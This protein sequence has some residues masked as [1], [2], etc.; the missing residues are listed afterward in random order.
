LKFYQKFPWFKLFNWL[1]RVVLI[2]VVSIGLIYVIVSLPSW[3]QGK[4]FG[5]LI[6]R[7]ITEFREPAASS[8][9]N[10]LGPL[11][12]KITKHPIL[13]SGFGTAV[14]YQSED[15]RILEEYPDGWISTYAFEWGW[16]DIWLKIGL[17][18]LGIY[19]L[20][21][22]KIWRAGWRRGE[23]GLLMGMVAI[24]VTSITSPYLNHPLG[25][26][27]IIL[28]SAIININGQNI[29]KYRCLE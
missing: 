1:G 23:I 18:G 12:K 16:L 24:A 10:Q 6:E 15:P 11:F 14:R 26:G 27:Y 20:L 22:S 21:L 9:M 5:A 29:N 8:R 28:I 17:V 7:R 3:S 4:A 25:I 19:L 2:F 13:G